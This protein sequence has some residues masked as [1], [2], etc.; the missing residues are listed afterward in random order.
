M[1]YKQNPLSTKLQHVQSRGSGE[2]SDTGQSTHAKNGQIEYSMVISQ[3]MLLVTCLSL[4]YGKLLSDDS[5][6]QIR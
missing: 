3:L 2:S 1:L 6:L 5:H 4:H